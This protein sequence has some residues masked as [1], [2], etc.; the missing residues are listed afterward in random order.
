MAEFP[1]VP[2]LHVTLPTLCPH[3]SHLIGG[4]HHV[5]YAEGI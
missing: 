3:L 1:R 5:L 4:Y 2:L